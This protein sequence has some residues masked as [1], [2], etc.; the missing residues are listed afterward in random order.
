MKRT[1]KLAAT[2]IAVATL[3]ACS[4]TPM[5]APV[6]D[7]PAVT[8]IQNQKL[9][10]TFKRKGIK[11][12]FD[13]GTFSSFTTGCNKAEPTAIEVT[14]YAES[15]GNSESNR[16][17]AFRVAEVKAKAKLRHF[18]QEDIQ[19][20]LVTKTITKNVEKANDKIKRRIAGNDVVTMDEDE[21]KEFNKDAN[22]ALRDN[23]NDVTR[24][25]VE[26]VQQNASGILRGVQVADEQVVDRQTVQVTI[27]WDRNSE[28]ASAFFSRRFS[29]R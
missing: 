25:V 28:A 16:E 27:R 23:T 2:V 8:A 11:L 12:E 20:S 26:V 6:T 21:A 29:G 24:Q 4:S 9:A 13:C 18:I 15:F 3:A 22:I 17:T 1:F 14:A 10:T 19:S 7:A 5:K